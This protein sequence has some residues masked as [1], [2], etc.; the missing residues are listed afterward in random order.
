[1]GKETFRGSFQLDN[2]SD[3]QSGQYQ[4]KYSNDSTLFFT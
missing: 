2:R 4:L 1:M 3:D